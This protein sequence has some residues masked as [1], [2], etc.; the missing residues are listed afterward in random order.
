[1][2]KKKDWVKILNDKKVIDGATIITELTNKINQ[3]VKIKFKCNCGEIY[4]KTTRQIDEVSGLFCK[5]CTQKNRKKKFEKTCEIRFGVKNPSQSL[6]IKKKKEDTCMK[7]HGVKHFLLTDEFKQNNINI[8]TEK[9]IFDNFNILLKKYEKNILIN[10]NSDRIKREDKIPF[11]CL[12]EN[13]NIE[14]EKTARM[15]IKMSGLFCKECTEK[16]R[17]VKTKK[18]I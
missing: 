11:L 14:Y 6:K 1:M 10:L 3:S 7:N 2:G 5:Q 13:C 18:K 15:I 16:I 8:L 12:T 17:Q 9:G 4:E